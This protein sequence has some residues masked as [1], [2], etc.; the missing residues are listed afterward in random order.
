MFG[1]C[2]LYFFLFLLIIFDEYHI[3]VEVDRKFMNKNNQ[4]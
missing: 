3:I 2:I 4:L 1:L